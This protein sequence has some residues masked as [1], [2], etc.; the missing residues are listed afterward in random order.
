LLYG[1]SAVGGVVN[2]IDNRIPKAPLAGL[3]GAAETRLGG[4]AQERAL[5]ALV[6]VGGA[7]FALHA[8]AFKRNT[9][10]LRVPAFDR[11]L[12]DGS[13][14]RRTRVLNSGSSAQGGSVGAS[15]V[16][17][18]GYVGASVDAYRNN[19][20]IVAEDDVGIEMRRD[21]L[22]LAGEWRFAKGYLSAL[23][24]Q[25]GATD[26]QHQEV[27]SDGTVGTVFKTRGGDGRLEIVHRTVPLGG[28]KLDGTAGAQ[29]E[30]STFSALGEE[31]F[32]PETR[33]RQAALFVL[34]RVAWDE[35][36]HVSAGVRTE[37]VT[38]R[39]AGDTDPDKTQFGAA[40]SRRYAPRSA[41]VAG[42]LN[43]NSQ[44]QVSSSWS[45]TERAPTSYEL[46]ANGVHAATAAFE[47]GNTKQARERGN[48]LD[49][50][51]AWR[52]AENRFKVSVFQ[53][54]FSNYIV[55]NA[56]GEADFVD[57]DGAAFPVFEFQ[58][59]NARLYG[60]ELE[61]ATRA[62][63]GGAGQLDI[64]GK[65]DLVRG[66]QQGTEQALPRLAP[67]RATVGLNWE[68]GGWTAR[69]EAQ[70]AAAQNRVP[71]TDTPTPGWTL[72][73]LSTGYSTKLLGGDALFFAKLQNAGNRLAY[74]ASTIGTVRPL[75][76]LPGRSLTFG[77]RV[78]F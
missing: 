72:V 37:H 29:F 39:S 35:W 13:F 6:E 38:V 65:L 16:N 23:R 54:R 74:S 5:S 56:T 40:Q 48:N 7:G 46:Y 68:G 67:L 2:A 11:P 73:N 75:S 36:G 59:V 34:G 3:S 76:P 50:A 1:G 33:T 20:G 62:W 14:E 4:A 51:L 17:D 21:K 47:R 60:L 53:S 77:M 66:S 69:A 45:Y 55:L 26:Y 28:V 15:W 58:G 78:N 18:Q 8:D 49:L 42:V 10:D 71:Q 9:S 41:S 61:A 57:P 64:D 22:A 19:Y 43:M 31:A 44:W 27:A 24:F 25:A 52:L 63:Q 70:H 30:S 32:V 12:D